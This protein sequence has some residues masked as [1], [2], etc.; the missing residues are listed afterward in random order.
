[1][2]DKLMEIKYK[3]P[4]SNARDIEVQSLIDTIQAD[5]YLISQDKQDYTK[6]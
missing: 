2:S 4:K 6:E 3:Q 5:C 1:M